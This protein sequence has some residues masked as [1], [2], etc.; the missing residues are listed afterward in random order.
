MDDDQAD[1]LTS[2]ELDRIEKAI[3]EV[4]RQQRS[5]Q[6]PVKL[7]FP[8]FWS[9]VVKLV[10]HLEQEVDQMRREGIGSARLSLSLI[11]IDAADE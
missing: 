7:P 9:L 11:H 4:A 3:F 5:K 2:V 10:I 6:I 1:A 8:D